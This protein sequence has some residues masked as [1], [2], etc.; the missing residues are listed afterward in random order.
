MPV[1][2]GPDPVV[3][4]VIEPEH[5]QFAKLIHLNVVTE[6]RSLSRASRQ[7]AATSGLSERSVF[8]VQAGG[9][10]RPGMS[11]VTLVPRSEYLKIEPGMTGRDLEAQDAIV[12]AIDAHDPSKE[13]VLQFIVGHGV[14]VMRVRH[15]AAD[16][17]LTPGER[18]LLLTQIVDGL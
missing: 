18:P 7:L 4:V 16:A 5:P 6:W 1:L 11:D 14:A 13:F 17:S 3:Q 2:S 10:S 8:S 12:A 9:G 15:H